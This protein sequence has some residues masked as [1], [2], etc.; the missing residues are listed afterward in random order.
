MDGAAAGHI[1]GGRSATPSTGEDGIH[2]RPGHLQHPTDADLIP[3]LIVQLDHGQPG[4]GTVGIGVVGPPLR[5]LLLGD[6]A[7]LPDRLDRFVI[8]RLPKFDG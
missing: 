2:G 6:G 4:L 1:G 8:D 7:R 3:P 5:P